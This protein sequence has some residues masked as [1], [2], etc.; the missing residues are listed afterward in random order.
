MYNI[1]LLQNVLM[2]HV[3]MDALE[4]VT[5]FMENVLVQTV[6]VYVRPDLKEIAAKSV[7]ILIHTLYSTNIIS[8][9]TLTLKV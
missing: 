3:A 6:A 5:V 2:T 4:T 8:V 7:H 9:Y 1:I